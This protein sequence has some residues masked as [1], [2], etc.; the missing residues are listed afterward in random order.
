[1]MWKLVLPCV[2]TAGR[3]RISGSSR[4]GASVW[5]IFC[6]VLMW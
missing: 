1:P 6:S 2:L 3:G 4:A 5:T